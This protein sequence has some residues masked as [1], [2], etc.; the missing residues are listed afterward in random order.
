[1][2]LS[3][4]RKP[5][6]HAGS[7]ANTPDNIPFETFLSKIPA[8]A[9]VC[10]INGLI[11]YYNERAVE[12]WGR[13]P[14]LND[15]HDKY[16]GS[17]KLFLPDGTRVPHEQCWMAL[18]LKNRQEYTGHE[19]IIERPDGTRVHALAHVSP[20]FDQAGNLVGAI[21][22]LIDIS[23]R[24]KMELRLKENEE[25]YRA[26]VDA[27]PECVKIVAADGSLLAMNDAGLEVIG[28]KNFD[29]V[30]GTSVFQLINPA[31]LD[32][33]RVFHDNVCAGNKANLEFEIIDLN[34]QRHVMESHA[35]PL[36][37]PNGKSHHLAIT[38]EISTL[39]KA[40]EAQTLLAAIVKSSED[41]IVTKTLEGRILSWNK[42]AE[43]LF[44]YAPEE[45]IGKHI[46]ML[47]PEDRYHEE[48]A[49][50][51]KLRRS[52]R[53]DHY[54]TVR[55]HKDGTPINI[56]LSIS[57]LY[58]KSGKI[59]GAS[60][61]ARDIT[62]QKRLKEALLEADRRKNEFLATLAHELRNPLAP[63]KNAL[64]I[65][66]SPKANDE[67]RNEARNIMMRQTHQMERLINDLMDVS[68][69]S[70][71]KVE[72]QNGLVALNDVIAVAVEIAK[73]LINEK[74]HCFIIKCPEEFI[75][76]DA[77]TVRLSQIFANLL[78]NAAKYTNPSGQIELTVTKD[79]NT[80]IISIK[81]NGIG[82]PPEMLPSIFDMFVQVDNSLERKQ[83]GL[84]IGLTLV[85]AL[86]KL[87]GGTIVAMSQGIGTG[88]EFIVRL[89]LALKQS[90]KIEVKAPLR[91]TAKS[92]RVLVVDDN[93]AS[94]KTLAWSLELMGHEIYKAFSAHEALK[95]AKEIN[96]DV[97]ML[98]IGLPDMNG[99]DLCRLL[100]QMPETKNT[101]MIAQTGW[102]QKEHRQQSKAAG[103]DYHLVKP[104][105][106]QLVEEALST[107]MHK[108]KLM[109]LPLQAAE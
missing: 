19:G 88:T 9:Y 33:Y 81:D 14:K 39:K 104:V 11:T 92:Y 94:T 83:G 41:A 3:I 63:I 70:Q 76:L 85:K 62:E 74:G 43:R 54:E 89:P 28:A 65:L 21:N 90:A 50:I 73:P 105:D 72:L 8:G 67:I 82:I 7:I 80:A 107:V 6:G 69:V 18:A 37:N 98:D 99:Y 47:I 106:M 31:D 48:D 16:C 36:H 13:T 56:S 4:L 40:E 30:K 100:R 1:M 35:V 95:L 103:F 71:G 96:P 68:R 12:L 5:K 51:A 29:E 66:Q 25:H 79:A 58:D 20:L 108:R 10:D 78:N 53:I 97:I 24:K 84:G 93:E 64:H 44:G 15:P 75:W 26:I 27:T 38:R 46:T 52:E 55:R 32:K 109:D 17:L 23:E 34:E 59:I 45:A 102:G 101:F 22:I 86:V 60:K 61:I 87:H 49:I 91:I 57:P 77:D 42:A 2:N